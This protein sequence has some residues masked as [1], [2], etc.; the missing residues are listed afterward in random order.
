MLKQQGYNVGN[1]PLPD[2]KKLSQM[3]SEHASNI[4]VWAPQETDR[5][6]ATG[7]DMIKIP[8]SQYQQWFSGYAST[9]EKSDT[10][11]GYS[12]GQTNGLRESA[13]YYN[14]C[15]P[16]WKHNPGTSSQLGNAGQQKADIWQ[17]PHTAKSRIYC[18]LRMAEA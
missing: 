4:G 2:E 11:L 14:S 18:V 8:L 9:A 12:S 15:Y 6:A 1:Q 10:D 5:R 16:L 7:K 13:G 17:R 3:M